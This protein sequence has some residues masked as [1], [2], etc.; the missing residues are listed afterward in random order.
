MTWCHTSRSKESRLA[1]RLKQKFLDTNI[2]YHPDFLM[3]SKPFP[4]MCTG[5]DVVSL[6]SFKIQRLLKIVI[7][8]ICL[9][10]ATQRWCNQLSLARQQSQDSQTHVDLIYEF[11]L[12]WIELNWIEWFRM[13]QAKFSA[14]LIHH[15]NCSKYCTFCCLLIL[16][17]KEFTKRHK[18]IQIH[19]INH[20]KCLS[21]Y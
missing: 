7:Y 2:T 14:S 10:T 17:L 16:F 1:Y 5:L 21:C 20:S 15:S 12:N 18:N 11:L 4:C 6:V 9:F 13:L 19:W 3:T 8:I